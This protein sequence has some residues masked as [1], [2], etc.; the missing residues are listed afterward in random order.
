MRV[1]RMEKA[2]ERAGKRRNEFVHSSFPFSLSLPRVRAA[3]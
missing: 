2:G 1:A 3:V